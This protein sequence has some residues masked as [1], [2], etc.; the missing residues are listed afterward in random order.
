MPS[1]DNSV[2][3]LSESL[4]FAAESETARANL[5]T[6]REDQR[7]VRQHVEHLEDQAEDYRRRY[8]EADDPTSRQARFYLEAEQRIMSRIAAMEE[9]A[10]STPTRNNTTPRT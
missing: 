8:A 1:E 9:N 4:R 3:A 5:L 6:D 2:R 7:Q 10:L